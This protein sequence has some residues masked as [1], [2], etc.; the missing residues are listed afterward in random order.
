VSAPTIDRP[1]AVDLTDRRPRRRRRL[2]L[3]AVVMGILLIA[4]ACWLVWF[5][6]VLSVKDVRVVGVEDARAEAALQAAGVPRGVPLATVDTE[7]ARQA[8][9]GLDWVESV[10][11]RR[12]W[13][14]EVVVAVTARVPIAVLAGA[15]DQQAVDATG[16]IFTPAGA[17]AKGLPKVRAKD[18]GLEAAMSVLA[19]LPD[20]LLRRVVSL[21]ATTRDDVDLTL[22]S[23][24]VVRWGSADQAEFKAQV[25][26]AVMKRKADVYDVS[27]PELPTTFR[28]R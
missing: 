6:S 15:G 10:D 21:S 2:R 18:V 28:A 8:V 9:L 13:P 25:L 27:A 16:R 5:S 17:T 7:S 12:G 11:V 26:R 3:L 4:G 24:D 23:G 14:N 1:V 20:D 22:R 19:T